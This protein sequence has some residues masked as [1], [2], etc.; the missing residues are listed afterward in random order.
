MRVGGLPVTRPARTAADLLGDRE[1]PGAVAQVIADAIRQ[2]F[3][4][5]A[6]FV[7]SLG[8]CAARFGLPRGDGRALV[9]WLL[10]LVAERDTASAPH[11]RAAAPGRAGGGRTS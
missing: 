3:D 10:D 9:A 2:G 5:P 11:G 1:D 7:A 4:Q 8:P 6:A